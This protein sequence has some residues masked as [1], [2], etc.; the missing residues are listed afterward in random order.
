MWSKQNAHKKNHSLASAEALV[1]AFLLRRRMVR[2]SR[3][4]DE[5]DSLA[6]I[7]RYRLPICYGVIL[8]IST[9][10][11]PMISHTAAGL[12]ATAAIYLGMFVIALAAFLGKSRS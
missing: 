9:F 1:L 5:T 11:N 2:G 8:L 6:I 10:K 12:R 7:A 3:F 4:S